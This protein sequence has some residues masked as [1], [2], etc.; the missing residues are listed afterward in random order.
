M[1]TDRPLLDPD[2]AIELFRQQLV[3]D[4]ENLQFD[5]PQVY[6]WWNTTENVIREAFG[7]GHPNV[8]EFTCTFRVAQTR[9]GHQQEHL[10]NIRHRKALLEGFIEQ[11]ESLRPTKPAPAVTVDRE[12]VY[13]AGQHFDAMLRVSR[14]LSIGKKSITI[15]DGYISE[16]VLALLSAKPASVSVSILTK[17]LPSSLIPIAKAFNQQHGGLSIRSSSAF[18]DR[19]IIVDDSDF[20]HFGA[21]IKDL[22]K[23]GF[24]FSRLEEPEM[25]ETLRRKFSNEWSIAKVEV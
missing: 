12:G 22:G 5:D 1:P 16:D 14:I 6:R 11:L 7:A 15:I 9:Q 18:H 3:K 21:S 8:S 13:F 17:P 10:A 4:I 25:I 2:R 23:R 24:M 19:F 20:Y